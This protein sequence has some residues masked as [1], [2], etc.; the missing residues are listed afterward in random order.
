VP[1]QNI[2]LGTITLPN[3]LPNG[4]IPGGNYPGVTSG[5]T[6]SAGGTGTSGGTGSAGGAG[7][8]KKGAMRNLQK[9]RNR[10]LRG[11]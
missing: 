1:T 10:A 2:N 8:K 6:G 3:S 11:Q 5:G 4:Y 7:P 9:K